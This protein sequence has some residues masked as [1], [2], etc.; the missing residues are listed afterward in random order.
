VKKAARMEIYNKYNGH[1]A[2]CGKSL[3]Y[4]DMQIDHVKPVS[5]AKKYDWFEQK[6]IIDNSVFLKSNMLPTCRRCNHY[7]R[8]LGLEGF[9]EYIKTLNDRIKQ[10]YIVKVGINFD[11]IQFSEWDGVFFFEKLN[12]EVKDD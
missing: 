3:D 11:T 2:Y 4:K 6:Y 1:C 9:R 8:S 12:N 5:S 7:K 10:I